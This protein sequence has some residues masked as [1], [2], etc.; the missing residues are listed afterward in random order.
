MVSLVVVEL[1]GG[2]NR[3]SQAASS[4][5]AA[6]IVEVSDPAQPARSAAPTKVACHLMARGPSKLLAKREVA[7]FPCVRGALSQGVHDR[8]PDRRS[9]DPACA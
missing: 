8:E 6:A 4:A 7:S 3:E 2:A 9:R 5:G 1:A